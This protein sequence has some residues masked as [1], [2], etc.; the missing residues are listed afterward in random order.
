MGE[1]SLEDW[2]ECEESKNHM[3]KL[4]SGKPTTEKV[5]SSDLDVALTNLDKFLFIGLYE[6]FKPDVRELLNV[7]GKQNVRFSIPHLI[8]SKNPGG[9]LHDGIYGNELDF[10]L[11]NYIKEK[12]SNVK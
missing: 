2:L 5:E 4:F 6:N 11:Y 3:T 9:L 8:K 7:L 12:R 1:M 10:E